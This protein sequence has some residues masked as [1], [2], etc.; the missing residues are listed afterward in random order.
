MDKC[1]VKTDKFEAVEETKNNL[2]MAVLE[3]GGVYTFIERDFEVEHSRN[4]WNNSKSVYFRYNDLCLRVLINPNWETIANLMNYYDGLSDEELKVLYIEEKKFN[5]QTKINK[6]DEKISKFKSKLSSINI[7]YNLK[8]EKLKSLKKKINE[9][10]AILTK[11]EE[12]QKLIIDNK[13]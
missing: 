10:K 12:L 4:T 3:Y 7:K 1:I 8:Q 9:H 13:N 5:A 2:E 11:V 6:L